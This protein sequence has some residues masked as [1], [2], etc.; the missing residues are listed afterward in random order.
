[1]KNV[2]F[3]LLRADEI[4]VREGQSTKDKTKKALLLYKDARCD[5]ARL[6]EEFGPYGWQREHKDVHG[7]SY[8][9]VGLWDSERN[10]WVWK[11]DAGEKSSASPEK[12]EASDAFKRACVNWG[13]GR[14]LYTAPKIWVLSGY[15]TY[16]LCVTDIQYSEKREICALTIEDKH[17]NIIYQLGKKSTSAPAKTAPAAP[18]VTKGGAV[19][20]AKEPEQ[21]KKE[22]PSGEELD[23]IYNSLTDR[24]RDEYNDACRQMKGA[25]LRNDIVQI[26]NRYI[27]ATFSPL[28]LDFGN[29]QIKEKGLK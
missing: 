22:K 27:H 12:G 2:E 5:M 16:D 8:C 24:E 15:N 3:R 29:K 21:T 25:L 11:W 28:L 6:D 1:M 23:G 20:P 17:G 18:V 4:E 10:C 19:Y 7:V 14:E 9:G 26:Y 13:I